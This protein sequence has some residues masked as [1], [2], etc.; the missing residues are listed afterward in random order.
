MHAH[1]CLVRRARHAPLTPAL[2]HPLFCPAPPPGLPPALRRRP[3]F[4]GSSLAVR[5]RVGGV[6]TQLGYAGAHCAAH[7]AA[8]VS[9]LL[10]LELVRVVWEAGGGWWS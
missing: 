5:A 7:L 3:E 2:P 8:A 1:A 4:H 9:L 6:A 10:L